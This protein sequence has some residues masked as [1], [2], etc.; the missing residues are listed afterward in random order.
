MPQKL[1][2]QGVTYPMGVSKPGDAEFRQERTGSFSVNASK[3]RTLKCGPIDENTMVYT[4]VLTTTCDQL[5]ARGFIVDH[6]DIHAYFKHTFSDVEVFPSCELIAMKALRDL[7]AM[8][9]KSC[10]LTGMMV[11]I[12]PINAPAGMSIQWP[13]G[14]DFR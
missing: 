10:N 2:V 13:I 9:R 12:T 4:V 7:C 6:Q 8:V 5:D 1:T 3:D 11:K 14:K